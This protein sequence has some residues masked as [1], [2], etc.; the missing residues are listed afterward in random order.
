[1]ERFTASDLEQLFA[2]VSDAGNYGCFEYAGARLGFY[3]D[4]PAMLDWFSKVFGGYFTVTPSRETDAVVYSS[5]DPAAFEFL[6]ECATSRGRPRSEQETEYAIDAR[7]RV[8]YR[9]AHPRKAY[10]AEDRF[11]ENCFVLSQ[12]DRVVLV[13]S[14]DTV[15]NPHVIV[16]RC[17]RNMM[18]LLLTERGWLTFHSAACVWNGTG[19]CILGN[20]FAGKT[21]T[22]LNLLSRPGAGLVTNDKLFLRATGGRIEGLGFPNNAGLRIGA[23]VAYPKL[24]GLV[25][26]GADS[27]FF[28]VDAEAF[29]DI[30]ATTS[31]DEL[32]S[33]PE[34]ISLLPTELAQQLDIPIQPVTDIELFLVVQFD[35]SLEQARLTPV[36]DPQRIKDHLGINFRGA[37]RV[38]QGFLH[39]LFDLHESTS[40][41]A[42][43]GLL[44]EVTAR[45]PVL[46]LRQNANTNE[47]AA[48]LVREVTQRVHEHT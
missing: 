41:S 4:D 10:E 48:A 37:D 15:T 23:L 7:H 21:S 6:K 13:S 42:L 46:E 11:E 40:S 17:L 30:A 14:S 8:I 22:L 45:V 29:R 3:S 34:R 18:R 16:W 39:G 26:K 28:H 44:D 47:H 20:K 33:R 19:I 24:A 25:D 32:H 35:P 2:D 9:R 43:A 5:R 31:A 27:F 1:M 12:P 36:T 38:K